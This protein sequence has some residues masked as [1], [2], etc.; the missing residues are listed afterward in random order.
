M[1]TPYRE[2]Q[3][4]IS[5]ETEAHLHCTLNIPLSEI[6]LSVRSVDLL[7]SR[8]GQ[9]RQEHHTDLYHGDEL[10]IRRGQTFQIEM[11]LNRP[12]NADTDKLHLDLKT[13]MEW[14]DSVRHTDTLREKASAM[15]HRL[16]N[17][18]SAVAGKQ[19]LKTETIRKAKH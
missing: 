19:G 12:F 4:H 2:Y 16:I 15:P 1:M 6:K 5:S 3:I 9:N 11:E 13:G 7:S 8:T 17:L 10:I 14:M 18:W